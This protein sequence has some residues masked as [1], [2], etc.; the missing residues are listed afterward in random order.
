MDFKAVEY[1]KPGLRG[2]NGRGPRKSQAEQYKL[3]CDWRVSGQTQD[4]F[5]KSHGVNPKTFSN[6]LRAYK[7]RSQVKESELTTSSLVECIPLST[8]MLEM[9]LPS[10]MVIRLQNS[11]SDKQFSLLLKE[12][13]QCN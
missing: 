12:L 13:C 4:A 1:A 10:G 3:V 7:S 11:I 2:K 8:S 5:C 6:W 9:E